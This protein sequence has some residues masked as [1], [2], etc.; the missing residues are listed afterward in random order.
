[1]NLLLDT[2]IW[3]WS[4]QEPHKLN[5][6]VHRVIADRRNAC[7]L[8]PVS[9]WEVIVLLEKKRIAINQ[10]FGQW[11]EQTKVEFDLQEAPFD[12]KVVHELRFTMLEHRD[13]A[14]RFLAATAMAHDMVLVTSDQRLLRVP[15]LKTLANI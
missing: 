6:E 5:S 3:L 11:F 4:A 1:V 10:D 13:P 2:H 7:Y 8:S 9:I 15:N 12:W 14:D